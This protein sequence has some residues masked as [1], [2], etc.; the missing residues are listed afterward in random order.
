MLVTY[1]IQQTTTS[2]WSIQK[3]Q[4]LSHL[5]QQAVKEEKR[6]YSYQLRKLIS[7]LQK[8]QAIET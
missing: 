6:E 2:I 1:M 7:E 8:A 5:F 4:S 3:M